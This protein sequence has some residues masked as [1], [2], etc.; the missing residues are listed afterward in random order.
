M[1]APLNIHINNVE[2]FHMKFDVPINTRPC[3]LS[4]E[5]FEFRRKFLQEELDE[6]VEAFNEGNLEK[7]ADALIDLEYVLLGTALW[8]GLGQI[9]SELHAEVHSANMAKEKSWSAEVSAANTGRAHKFDVI[10]PKGWTPPD[11]KSIIDKVS[12]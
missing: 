9:W 5:D 12:K 2:D 4:R 3:Q 10:K 11:L 6:L 8:M 7:Q 1:R